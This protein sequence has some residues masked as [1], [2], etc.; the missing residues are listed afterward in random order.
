MVAGTL[1]WYL[2]TLGKAALS[3]TNRADVLRPG[4][5]VLQIG[6]AVCLLLLFLVFTMVMRNVRRHPDEPSI[7]TG[8]GHVIV[9]A[10][11]LTALALSIIVFMFWGLR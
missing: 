7:A 11:V 2:V 3:L 10:L 1:G 4:W 6:A 8:T 5:T 9:A